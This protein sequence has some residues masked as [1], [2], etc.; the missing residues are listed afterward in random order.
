M[1]VKI[2]SP[3]VNNSGTIT[4]KVLI[5]FN[6]MIENLSSLSDDIYLIIASEETINAISLNP[7]YEIL[8]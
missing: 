3:S 2:K 7:D 1:K 4:P 5:D 8:E 6:E